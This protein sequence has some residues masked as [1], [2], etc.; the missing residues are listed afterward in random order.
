MLWFL[1]GEIYHTS[2]DSYKTRGDYSVVSDVAGRG[3]EVD[4]GS[5]S[6]AAVCERVH[7]SHDVVPELALF[8]GRHDKVNVVR[9]ALHLLD[10]G[11]GDGQT[12]SLRR[13]KN[14]RL[15]WSEEE[16][17]QRGKLRF[18]FKFIGLAFQ[19]K[20]MNFRTCSQQ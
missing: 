15:R 10:L 1:E 3:P 6:G 12:Q 14:K 7:V 11:V 9:V 13:E 4:D 16:E 19:I 20:G 5:G 8:F 2:G 18:K 17:G